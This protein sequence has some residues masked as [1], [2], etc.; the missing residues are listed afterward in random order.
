MHTTRWFRTL[1][2]LGG[3]ILLS[4][5]ACARRTAEESPPAPP[6]E[7][8]RQEPAVGGGPPHW[9]PERQGEVLAPE[10]SDEIR[11]VRRRLEV[12]RAGAEAFTEAGRPAAAAR[13]A[14]AIRARELSIEGRRDAEAELV[15]EAAPDRAELAELLGAAAALCRESG[16]SDR[17]ASLAGLSET[18]AEQWRRRH[19]DFD[20][21]LDSLSRRIEILR[22]ARAAHAEAQHAEAR[23]AL[24]RVIHLGELQLV[25]AGAEPIAQASE[26]LSTE[27]V[28]ELLRGAARLYQERGHETR[29]A[30]CGSLAEFYLQRQRAPQE[31]G[32]QERH[33][34]ERRLHQ[35]HELLR[36]TEELQAML[37]G[38]RAEILS[39]MQR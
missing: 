18:Y 25:E 24:E 11:A 31:R 34:R 9:T 6:A 2:A 1:V 7:E 29:A 17:A 28:V 12:M 3:S 27:R 16:Q 21:G 8:I 5:S 35:L 30:A 38:I 32:G 36:Q 13:I 33:E 15:R 4:A 14:Q 37:D 39:L 20:G 19:P 22:Y 26:G 10:E 23:D